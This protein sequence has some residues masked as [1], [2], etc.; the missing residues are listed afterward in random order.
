MGQTAAD[1]LRQIILPD[2]MQLVGDVKV[3]RVSV[4]AVLTYLRRP[5]LLFDEQ[6]LRDMFGEAD[7]KHQGSLATG[8]L[9]GALQGRYRRELALSFAFAT[10]LNITHIASYRFPKRKHGQADWLALVSV[11]LRRPL[12]ELQDLL[13]PAPSKRYGPGQHRTNYNVKLPLNL[14]HATSNKYML[15]HH[16]VDCTT[17]SRR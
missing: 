5:Q 2:L 13:A 15:H 12:K 17:F 14:S 3:Q 8:P 1:Q 7:F 9:T 11:I 6:L 16:S 10:G 4:D